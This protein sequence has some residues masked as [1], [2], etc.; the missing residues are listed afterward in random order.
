MKLAMVVMLGALLSSMGACQSDMT[1][2]PTQA[3]VS[4]VENSPDNMHR[5]VPQGDVYLEEN[6]DR[7]DLDRE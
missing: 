4:T 3:R 1:G 6:I 2:P 7:Y 5:D